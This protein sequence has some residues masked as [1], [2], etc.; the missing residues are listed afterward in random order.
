MGL[1][2]I[3]LLEDQLGRFGQLHLG[4]VKDGVLI[5]G[6]EGLVARQHLVDL[7]PIERPAV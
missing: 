3:D 5:V 2:P 7:D 1:Q 4:R 6:L